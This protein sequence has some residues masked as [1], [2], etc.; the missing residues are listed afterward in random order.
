[1]Q[2]RIN[3]SMIV[4]PELRFDTNALQRPYEGKHSI[5]TAASDLIIGW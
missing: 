3:K 5:F 1:V 2:Y 4:R